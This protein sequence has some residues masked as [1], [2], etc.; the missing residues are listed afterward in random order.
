MDSPANG[1]FI[2]ETET[3]HDSSDFAMNVGDCLQNMLKSRRQAVKSTEYKDLAEFGLKQLDYRLALLRYINFVAGQ[4][5]GLNRTRQILAYTREDR[6]KGYQSRTLRAGDFIRQVL[7]QNVSR[8][9]TIVDH[10]ATVDIFEKHLGNYYDGRVQQTDDPVV[11]SINLLEDKERASILYAA[12]QTIGEQTARE[13]LG[14]L[15]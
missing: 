13:N 14:V 7:T 6:L 5:H 15:S 11:K 8:D 9:S 2:F 12:W 3:L 1:A 4:N 10:N